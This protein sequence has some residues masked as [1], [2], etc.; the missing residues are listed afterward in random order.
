MQRRSLRFS[1]DSQ[2]HLIIARQRERAL[3][4]VPGIKR[5]RDLNRVIVTQIPCE[6]VHAFVGWNRFHALDAV[7]PFRRLLAFFFLLAGKMPDDFARSI[8]NIERDFL[9][10]RGLEII[11]NHC[12]RAAGYRRRAGACRIPPGNANVTQSAVDKE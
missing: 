3:G 11:I 6:P 4:A 1:A 7:R 8:E 5:A 12:A 10:R 9:F 2:F